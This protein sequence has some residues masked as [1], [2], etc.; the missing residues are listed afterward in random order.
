MGRYLKSVSYTHLNPY[1]KS[2]DSVLSVHVPN[3]YDTVYVDV[4]ART[5][6]D[7]PRNE[8]DVMTPVLRRCTDNI[9]RIRY[10]NSGTVRCV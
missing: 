10:C 6:F 3:F 1:W 7:C 5:L 9:Y 4:P 2:C 8:V